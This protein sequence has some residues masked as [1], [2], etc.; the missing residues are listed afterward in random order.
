[1]KIKRICF[2]KVNSVVCDETEVDIPLGPNDVLMRTLYSAVSAGTELAKFTGLQEVKY[3]FLPG[4]RAVGEVI[5]VG[6]AVKDVRPGDRVF[7]HTPHVSHAKATGFY[8]KAPKEV[9]LCHA[10]MVG[11]GLVAMTA[12]RVGRPELGDRA[13]VIG[14]GAVGNL[15]AQFLEISGVEVIA[16]DTMDKRLEAARRCGV[17]HT[18]NPKTQDARATVFALTGGRGVE[19]VIEATGNPA[20][21]EMACSVT[22]TQ[23]QVILLG[24]PRGEFKT[25][26]TPL[27]NAVHIWRDHGSIRLDGAHEWRYP[28]YPNAFMKHSMTRNAEIIFRLMANG[29]LKVQDLISHVLKPSQAA[30]AFDGLLNRKEEYHG[31]VFDWTT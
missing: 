15:C 30:E 11:L 2:P 9:N 23:A 21:I 31:V 3:P 16:A 18:I 10:P 1:M 17:T 13:L 29:R 27:L 5:A 4:N 12:L 24:S 25:D 20:V 7:T 6:S 26:V 28:Q 14:M 8:V 19:Y 22:A